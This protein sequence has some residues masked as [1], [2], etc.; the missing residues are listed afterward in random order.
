MSSA[1]KWDVGQVGSAIRK[2]PE[3]AAEPPPNPLSPRQM[4][5]DR[6]WR[7]YRCANYDNRRVDWNGK[8]HVGPF[9]RDAIVQ[10]GF[11][12]PGF[13]DA[14]QQFPLKYRRPTAPYYLG[15]VIVDRFT[16]LLFSAKRHP[17]IV[18]TDDPDTESWLNGFVESTR[19]WARMIQ[20]R[21]LGGAM[22]AVGLGLKF[23]EGKPFVE[24]HDPRY[25]TPVF[26]DRET[27][28]V[29]AVEKRYQFVDQVRDSE[30]RWVEGWFWYRRIITAT[31]DVVWPR[32]PAE[33]YGRWAEPDWEKE[34]RVVVAHDLGFCPVVWMHNRE[35]QDDVD[36]D[37]DCHGIFDAIEAI[38]ALV[39]QANRGVISN[40][41]PTLLLTTDG[42]IDGLRKGSDNAVQLEK[43]GSAQYLEITGVGPRA[44]M[45]MASS[46]EKMAQRVARCVLDDNFS[47]P[48]RTQAETQQN[49]SNMVEQAD[50]LREQYGE[51][52]VKRLLSMALKAAARLGQP[53]SRY[54][55]DGNHETIEVSEVRLPPNKDGTER[56]LGFGETVELVWPDYYEPSAGEVLQ[57]V[58]AAAQAKQG[59]IID[60]EHATR[61][62]AG[63]F[64]IENV[65]EV[66]AKAEEAAQAEADA[67][68]AQIQEQLAR[69]ETPPT[70]AP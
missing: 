1:T 57:A 40:C 56:T 46:L 65:A 13:Y 49:Y 66:S 21:T 4:E 33:Q 30:G 9:E 54:S 35:V 64:D 19:L 11:L 63:Y 53:K 16:G 28:V 51:L 38:D 50:V 3:V 68:A 12:P 7:Y 34:D 48:A 62:V 42:A 23:V 27:R 43:G 45:E 61:Y 17:K 41:D 10:S 6:L 5:L 69:G 25:T 32:V 18:C 39:S 58:Q 20:A 2:A 36:G 67:F 70:G 47:G 24:V 31:H 44:A 8:E 52:G 60:G 15:K 37:P 29:R 14:G 55:D 22:G 59:G 26:T